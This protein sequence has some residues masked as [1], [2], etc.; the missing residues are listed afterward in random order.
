M[1]P[2]SGMTGGTAVLQRSP[3]SNWRSSFKISHDDEEW[4]WVCLVYECV[5]CRRAALSRQA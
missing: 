2:H 3:S 5:N 4:R 1:N